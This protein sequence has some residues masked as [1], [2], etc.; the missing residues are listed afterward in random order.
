MGVAKVEPLN[1]YVTRWKGFNVN[2]DVLWV[3]EGLEF[4]VKQNKNCGRVQGTK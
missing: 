1:I 3:V 4:R 2:Y